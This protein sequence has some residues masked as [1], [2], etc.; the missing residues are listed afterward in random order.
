MLKFRGFNDVQ[1]AAGYFFNSFQSI[2]INDKK[3]NPPIMIAANG[4]KKK[5][6]TTR[7]AA[8]SMLPLRCSHANKAAPQ[9]NTKTIISPKV[10]AKIFM[11]DDSTG[12]P[13]LKE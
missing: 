9:I 8:G 11:D 3:K 1:H 7:A 4:I 13:V 10:F 5:S 6:K 2:V 12:S